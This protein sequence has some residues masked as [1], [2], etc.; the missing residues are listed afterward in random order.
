MIE[1]LTVSKPKGVLKPLPNA[2]FPKV[3]FDL[4]A[5]HLEQ[6]KFWPQVV[7]CLKPDDISISETGTSSFGI[8]DTKL[9]SAHQSQ[10][11]YGSIGW[12]TG[13]SVG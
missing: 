13:A 6:D 1:A 12:A 2:G 9:V 4:N 7:R 5:D 3:D 10:V 11:L 8:L